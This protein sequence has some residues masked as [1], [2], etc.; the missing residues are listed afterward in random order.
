MRTLTKVISSLV[1]CSSISSVSPVFAAGTQAD[2]QKGH[3]EFRVGSSKSTTIA[4][5]RVIVI[6]H[7]GEIVDS[8]LTNTRGVWDTSVPLYEM[9]WNQ[10]FDAKG[11]VNAVVLANGYNEQA[12]FVVPNSL[13]TVQ[14]V[15]L[16][17]IVPNGR[18]QPSQS[19]GNF[20]IHDLKLYVDHYAEELNLKKQPPIPGDPGM[21]HGVQNSDRRK[22]HDTKFTVRF[23]RNLYRNGSRTFTACSRERANTNDL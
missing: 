9:K 2:Q 15:V 4:G 6:N 16:Q 5:A 11:V 19:L 13:N 1:L 14:P 3:I 18:N 20:S 7:E 22:T 8:G 10:G 23:V 12:V 21:R 17:P